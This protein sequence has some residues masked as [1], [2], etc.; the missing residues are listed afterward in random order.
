MQDSGQRAL[1]RNGQSAYTP[2]Q[3]VLPSFVA[4]D[5]LLQTEPLTKDQSERLETIMLFGKKSDL[6]NHL[7]AKRPTFS[8]KVMAHGAHEQNVETERK[9]Q[10]LPE[11]DSP[12][13][14]EASERIQPRY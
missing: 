5:D 13:K 14:T 10:S 7:S 4:G 9:E 8:H 6:K 12:P 3:S 2:A 11:K 1:R